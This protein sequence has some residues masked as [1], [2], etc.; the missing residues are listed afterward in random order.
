MPYN[1]HGPSST[2]SPSERSRESLRLLDLLAEVDREELERR[3][4]ARALEFLEGKWLEQ[5]LLAKG[6]ELVV[7]DAMLYWLRDIW[8]KFA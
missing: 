6:Q 4:S 5:S 8:E 3:V 1:L 7:T 2:L